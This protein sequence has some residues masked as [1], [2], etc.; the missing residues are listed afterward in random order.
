[1]IPFPSLLIAEPRAEPSRHGRGCPGQP[2]L[3]TLCLAPYPVQA[4]ASHWDL[5]AV[6]SSLKFTPTTI[7]ASCPS[8][9]F[10]KRVNG[11]IN[12]LL[13]W[14]ARAVSSNLSPPVV[15]YLCRC[16]VSDAQSSNLGKVPKASGWSQVHSLHHHHPTPPHPR[17]SSNSLCSC[18]PPAPGP[19][20]SPLPSC[21]LLSQCC[22]SSLKTRL[23]TGGRGKDPRRGSGI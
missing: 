22:V 21:R 20:G 11:F 7:P 2:V 5:G 8:A 19:L 3:R 23:G 6:L 13:S 15:T 10:W 1:M 9:G 17:P 12:N 14:G 18:P 4:G 16:S